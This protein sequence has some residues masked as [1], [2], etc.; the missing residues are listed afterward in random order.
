[1][2]VQPRKEIAPKFEHLRQQKPTEVNEVNEVNEVY[3]DKLQK[4]TP[5]LYLHCF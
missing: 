1:M 5:R 2:A 4:K 3:E